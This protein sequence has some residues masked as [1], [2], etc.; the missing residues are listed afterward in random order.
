M[1]QK[2]IHSWRRSSSRTVS[3][4]SKL[5]C[6]VHRLLILLVVACDGHA[7]AVVVQRVHRHALVDIVVRD[8]QLASEL[9]VIVGELADFNI[10]D[11]KSLLFLGSAQTE[12]GHELANEVEGGEDEACA[13]EG[14]CA[15]SE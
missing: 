3:P 4:V 15:A 8:L 2:G 13:N 9:D 14:V 6:R 11:T 12:C 5:V 10:I 1:D 7:S